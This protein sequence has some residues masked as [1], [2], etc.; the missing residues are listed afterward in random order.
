MI[1]LYGHPRTGK[2]TLLQ[3]LISQG[4]AGFDLDAKVLA[5]AQ[6]ANPNIKSAAEL[7][8]KDQQLF[9]SLEKDILTSPAHLNQIV[10]LGGFSLKHSPLPTGLIIYL[11]SPAELLFKRWQQKKPQALVGDPTAF[12]QKRHLHYLQTCHCIL[13]SRLPNITQVIA[14]WQQ[15]PPCDQVT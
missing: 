7:F 6:K 10:A 1:Y 14:F 9:F 13:D 8:Q 3:Q 12:Y 11:K 4:L 15:N 2:S 5:L